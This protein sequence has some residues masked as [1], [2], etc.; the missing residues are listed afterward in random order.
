[1]HIDFVMCKKRNT[2]LWNYVLRLISWNNSFVSFVTQF[3]WNV[4]TFVIRDEKVSIDNPFVQNS[5][6]YAIKNRKHSFCAILKI[7][8]AA[9]VSKNDCLCNY[10]HRVFRSFFFKTK[11]SKKQVKINSVKVFELPYTRMGISVLVMVRPYGMMIVSTACR[12]NWNEPCYNQP[13]KWLVFFS[14][15]EINARGKNLRNI[16]GSELIFITDLHLLAV[17]LLSLH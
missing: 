6:D 2:E 8:N 11:D 15:G 7:Q 5:S 10:F 4:N 14:G 16:S 12:C 17:S 9:I 3:S 1:M 13:L